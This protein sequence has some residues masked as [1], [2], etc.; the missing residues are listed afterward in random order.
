VA[1][2]RSKSCISGERES[3]QGRVLVFYSCYELSAIDTGTRLDEHEF[4]SGSLTL[5]AHWFG[6]RCDAA[7]QVELSFECV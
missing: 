4:H 6:S 1:R 3:F 7:V 5:P 2:A